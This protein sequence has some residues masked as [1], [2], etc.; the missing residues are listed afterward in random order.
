M[1]SC[2]SVHYVNNN[3]NSGGLYSDMYR[4]PAFLL[5]TKRHVG[6]F[7]LLLRLM[8]MM[9]MTTTATTTLYAAEQLGSIYTPGCAS[10]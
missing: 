2:S 8:M 6:I 1:Q 10:T 3:S 5:W 9:M 4:G 7:S